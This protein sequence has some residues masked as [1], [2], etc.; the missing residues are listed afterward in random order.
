MHLFRSQWNFWNRLKFLNKCLML[1]KKINEKLN[2]DCGCL[3]FWKPYP[4]AW[5]LESAYWNVWIFQ[6][7]VVFHAEPVR[8]VRVGSFRRFLE[9]PT[10][11]YL[12]PIYFRS[13]FQAIK[14]F[15]IFQPI[16]LPH[17]KLYVRFRLPINNT[18]QHISGAHQM[19]P[20]SCIQALGVNPFS[21]RFINRTVPWGGFAR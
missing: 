1:F 14:I 16:Y 17:Y 5:C 7:G 4:V 2:R 13:Q 20:P 3:V 12:Q 18:V 21:S 11:R 9:K 6:H 19:E 10:N 8:N 15:S